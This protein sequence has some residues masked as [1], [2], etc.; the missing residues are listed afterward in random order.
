MSR[1]VWEWCG[2]QGFL[3]VGDLR[4]IME[5]HRQLFLLLHLQNGCD[6]LDPF[7][8]FPYATNNI[9]PTQGG[10]AMAV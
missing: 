2:T 3:L 8:D 10:V 1:S 5:L 4:I 6:L 9:M 7:G